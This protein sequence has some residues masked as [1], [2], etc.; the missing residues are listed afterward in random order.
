MAGR[1]SGIRRGLES[2]SAHPEDRPRRA[3]LPAHPAGRQ[4]LLAPGRRTV[5]Y[6]PDARTQLCGG[7]PDAVLVLLDDVGHM[8][9]AGH[10][11]DFPHQ[12]RGAERHAGSYST[13]A[14]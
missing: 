12:D 5:A 6:R 8:V 10:K 7:A 4:P 11:A 13:R 1:D 9:Y 3:T 14:A 2:A